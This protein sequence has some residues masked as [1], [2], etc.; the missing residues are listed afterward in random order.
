[1]TTHQTTADRSA[2][3]A[4]LREWYLHL[5]RRLLLAVKERRIAAGKAEAF[6]RMMIH[7][8]D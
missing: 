8:L 4:E 7:F 6:D 5:R 1:V 2:Q 3:A